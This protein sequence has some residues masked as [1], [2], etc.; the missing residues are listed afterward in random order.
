MPLSYDV[1][2][3]QIVDTALGMLVPDA[4]SGE[5]DRRADSVSHKGTEVEDSVTTHLLA[6]TVGPVQEFIAAARRTRDLWFG[7][8]VLS[9]ISREVAIAVSKHGKLIFPASTDVPNVAN[10]ILDR[11]RTAGEVRQRSLLPTAKNAAQEE[12]RLCTRTRY[13]RNLPGCHPLRD[14]E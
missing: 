6:I 5:G 7:S 13:S 12:W 10:I 9:E 11:T 3:N 4:G 14:L 8:Y 2:S 1:A